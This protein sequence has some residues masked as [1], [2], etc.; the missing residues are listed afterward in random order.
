M[1]RDWVSWLY[2]EH[3]FCPEDKDKEFSAM[4]NITCY[5]SSPGTEHGGVCDNRRVRCVCAVFAHWR[6]CAGL[7]RGSSG[8]SGG[9]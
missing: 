3:C 5:I 4:T 6:L 7:T 1:I 9:S 2:T 8:L